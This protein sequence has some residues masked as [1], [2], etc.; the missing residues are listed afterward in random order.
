MASEEADGVVLLDGMGPVDEELILT[1]PGPI[2]LPLGTHAADYII[3]Q[4]SAVSK[5]D[6]EA[7]KQLFKESFPLQYGAYFYEGLQKGQYGGRP[8]LTCVAR[9]DGRII[10][11]ACGS[12]EDET[13]G[14]ESLRLVD[15]GCKVYLMTLAVDKECV[16]ERP[17]SFGTDS[18]GQG[19]A[20]RH[21]DGA[22]AQN[23][24]LG[25]GHARMHGCLPARDRL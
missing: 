10:G 17:D 22:V 20:E 11:A 21:C 6:V 3:E 16:N 4:L 18:E 13:S 14:E 19:A 1:E 8:L 25:D 24:A 12:R 2:V 5:E 23:H 9:R 7:I 15:R